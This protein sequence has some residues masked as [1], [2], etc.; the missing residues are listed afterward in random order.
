MKI[1]LFLAAVALLGLTLPAS[2]AFDANGCVTAFEPGTDYFQTRSSVDHADNFSVAYFDHYKVVT[3]E[4][5]SPGAPSEAYVL[6][7]CGTPEPE[8]GPELAHAPRITVP[9][10]SLF[11]GSTSQSP[12]LVD[13]GGVDAVTGVARRDF[14]ATPA[15][16]EH[17]QQT[18]VVEYETS[19][20][21][22]VEAVVAAAPD[23]FMAGGGGEADV[24]RIAA[25]GIPVVNFAEWQETSPLGRAEW[26]KF[27]GLF[28][29][30]ESKANAAFADVVAQYD[31][32]L[33]LVADV[34]QSDRPLVLS[35]QSFNGVFFAAGGK[36]FIARLIHDAGGRY[37]FANDTS[38][39]S[40]QIRDSEQLIVAARD[41]KFWIQ[42]SIH[43]QTLADIEADDPRLAAL[44]AAQ[45]GQVWIPD[46]LKGPNG[47]V[48]FY[49]LGSMR[50]DMV[51]MDLI[52][53]VHPD[54]A[55]FYQR[56]FN[57]SITL[58]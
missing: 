14:I 15:L 4:R 57:R 23:V 8:L 6:V 51:L 30:A 42:A 40:F 55:P 2:A 27:M 29:N 19:G 35:G 21:V 18:S 56:V 32:A 46:A 9:V 13:V 3:V 41:A 34:P 53:I 12:A 5:P 31:A 20:V 49:E 38:T 37:V 10:H 47:G 52:S 58:D 16:I 48:Q 44:P 43:Y 54:R 7:Q 28:F 17:M 24:G 45:S 25:A 36:S 26:V 50:P 11:S 1:R 33:A 39:G 22:N